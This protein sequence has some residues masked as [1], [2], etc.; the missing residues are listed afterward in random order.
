MS[1]GPRPWSWVGPQVLFGMDRHG[2]CTVSAGPGLPAL[3]YADGELVGTGLLDLF[4]DDP[5][6]LA[7]VHRALAG[8]TFTVTREIEGRTLCVSYQ[9]L[10]DASGLFTG[11]MAVSTDVTDQLADARGL[12]QARRRADTLVELSGAL[13][14]AELS[15]RRCW[16]RGSGSSPRRS[17]RQ[18]W[19][20]C[21]WTRRTGRT[22][23]ARL[24]RRLARRRGPAP[25]SAGRDA[26]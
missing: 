9:A 21:S 22:G 6:I 8:D 12:A 13:G 10:H 7:S 25:A 11:S 14:A 23:S 3:G 16:T 5:A 1:R 2:T 26:G 15:P 19:A 20:G 24:R 17:P 18:P 4:R